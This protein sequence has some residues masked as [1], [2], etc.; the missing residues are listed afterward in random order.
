MKATEQD[1][2]QTTRTDQSA[3]SMLGELSTW[4]D[5]CP[6]AINSGG[7]QLFLELKRSDQNHNMLSHVRW[8]SIKK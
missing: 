5:V 8:S 6:Q 7:T 4:T 3:V 1:W 2:A